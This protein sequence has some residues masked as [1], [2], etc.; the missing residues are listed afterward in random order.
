MLPLTLTSDCTWRAVRGDILYQLAIENI[1]QHMFSREES[2]NFAKITVLHSKDEYSKVEVFKDPYFLYVQIDFYGMLEGSLFLAP[3]L[4][5][6]AYDRYHKCI[7]E[8]Y[9]FQEP[10][11]CKHDDSLLHFHCTF[12]KLLDTTESSEFFLNGTLWFHIRFSF[13]GEEETRSDDSA[14]EDEYID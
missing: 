7:G 14:E 9:S 2:T 1:V 13:I 6:T 12:R 3:S 5:V 10:C 11:C 8:L 4:S